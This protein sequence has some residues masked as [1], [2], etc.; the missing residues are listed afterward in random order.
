[1]SAAMLKVIP[2]WGAYWLRIERDAIVMEA[3]APKAAAVIGPT[4]NRVSPVVE[5]IPGTAV[6]AATSNDYG[7][8]LKG[9]LDLYRSE[10][11]LKPMLDQL[12]SALGLVGGEDAALGW[13]GD[14][15]VVVNLADGTPEGGLIAIPTD[16]A[17]AEHL[18]TSLRSFIV[19]AGA[20]QGL[21]VSD[22]TYNG[23]TI[24]TVDLGDLATLTGGTGAA[25]SIPLPTGHLQIAYAVTDQVVVVGSG[26]GF[27]K[28]VLD[29]T[30]A[31]SLKSNDRYRKLADRAGAGT[32]TTFV[33]ITTIRG[34]VE[35]AAA[36]ATDLTG[37]KAL[38]TYNSEIKPFLA[39]FDAIV[40]SGSVTGNT[41]RSVIYITLK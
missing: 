39:P 23:T 19:L 5:H 11:T 1:M 35:K 28:H 22:E 29:T 4:D 6:V 8:T 26:P 27:V 3:V 2:D 31:T 30:M 16:K 18:F 25:V 36:D 34:L 15:A 9:M 37:P 33:D 7:K 14:T 12:D 40:A 10:P 38:A 13:A 20:Q 21:S 24:T 41:T 32:G 17:A